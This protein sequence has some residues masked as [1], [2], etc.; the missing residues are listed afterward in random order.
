MIRKTILPRNDWRNK[1]EQL[2]FN[3]HTLDNTTYWDE[4]ACYE[5]NYEQVGILE[6]TT[7]E[8]YRLCLAAV[9]HVIEKKLYDAFFIPEEFIPLIEKSWHDDSPCIYGRFD[10][11]WNGHLE[12]RPKMLEF[13]AD[14]PTSLF[15]GA[16]VQWFWLEDF[17]KKLDQ[18]NS[19]HERL[20]DGWKF[21]KPQ[22]KNET[23][24]FSC[25]DQFPEDFV[26]TSYL[27]ECAIQAGIE[28]DIIAVADIGWNGSIFTNLE[29]KKINTIFKLYPWEWLFNE[30][31]GKNIIKTDTLWIEP[32]WK[33]LLSSKAILPILWEL[34]PKHPNLL[35]C[36]FDTPK[37]MK[38]Y[39]KKPLFSREGANIEVVENNSV[40]V[41]TEG[42]YGDE[43]FIYQELS[44]LPEFNG[45]Y[46][47]I[48]SWTI[49]GEAAGVGIRE[50]KTLITDNFSRF[51]PHYIKQDT[52]LKKIKMKIS[53]FIIS[54]YKL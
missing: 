17:D 51:I 35:E 46:P 10:L 42:E 25:L 41:F 11:S 22:F 28:T 8:L 47:V 18:F 34:F 13:N 43:G 53:D 38:N 2:G 48:G 6:N 26:N 37:E 19:I 3:Y 20:I 40:S 33:I 5:F 9:D 21:L 1:V 14:T 39:V 27:R 36:Y 50:S 49:C 29:E 54:K 52:F 44:K 16:V 31:F 4:T 32:P 12:Q 15:E 23:L 45:N 24:Y 7:N 30:E